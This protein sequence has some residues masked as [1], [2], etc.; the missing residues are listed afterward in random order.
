MD[1]LASDGREIA[2]RLTANVNA[3]TEAE[4]NV[5]SNLTTVGGELEGTGTDPG[6]H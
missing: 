4:Q 3:Y 6:A 1:N 5:H 2:S